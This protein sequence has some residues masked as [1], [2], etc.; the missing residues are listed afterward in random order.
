ML[1]FELLTLNKLLQLTHRWWWVTGIVITTSHLQL[2]P[3]LALSPFSI[4]PRHSYSRCPQATTTPCR[5]GRKEWFQVS[6]E[7]GCG[8]SAKWEPDPV[9][10][11]RHGLLCGPEEVKHTLWDKVL[12]SWEEGVIM[13]YGWISLVLCSA[14]TKDFLHQLVSNQFSAQGTRGAGGS[15]VGAT[16]EEERNQIMPA[17]L[18]GLKEIYLHLL[19]PHQ[20][21]WSDGKS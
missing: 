19:W 6:L 2:F 3:L 8:H 16:A 18:K 21:W 15:T 4:S 11:C 12:M 1:N 7:S 20:T 10:H 5:P 14:Q 13:E 17:V 9:E